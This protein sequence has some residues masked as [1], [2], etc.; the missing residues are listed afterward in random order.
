MSPMT[1]RK[2]LSSGSPHRFSTSRSVRHNPGST[3]KSPRSVEDKLPPQSTL[4]LNET[5]TSAPA[6]PGGGIVP[7]QIR[8]VSVKEAAFRLN[9]SADSI[10]SWL[11][12]GR[13]RGWQPGGRGCQIKVLESSIEQAMKNLLGTCLPSARTA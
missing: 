6:L 8:M 9:I 4:Q 11:R 7:S 1:A 13:L 12:C 5:A 3:R 2:N 10:Y